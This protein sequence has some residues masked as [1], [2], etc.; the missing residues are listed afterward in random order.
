MNGR[1]IAVRPAGEDRKKRDGHHGKDRRKREQR[2]RGG[3]R[4]GDRGRK[5]QA[6]KSDHGHRS[7]R[8]LE[9]MLEEGKITKQ[10]FSDALR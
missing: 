7:K 9:A 4:K 5:K 6:G 1:K 2:G 8:E 3:D 10:E